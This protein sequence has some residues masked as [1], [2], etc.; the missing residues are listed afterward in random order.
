MERQRFGR[1]VFLFCCVQWERE[2]CVT[3]TSLKQPC[4]ILSRQLSQASLIP[5]LG[6]FTGDPLNT[7]EN[8]SSYRN[9]HRKKSPYYQGT[10]SKFATSTKHQFTA[11]KKE[12]GS[13][14][15][16]QPRY[17]L[18]LT[19]K[20]L[21]ELAYNESDLFPQHAFPTPPLYKFGIL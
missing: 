14:S 15:G 20:L 11:S 7:W 6:V 12:G 9:P 3:F 17:S 1:E 19:A 4:S 8:V 21:E 5:Q 18:L 13:K 16:N 2:S 10:E